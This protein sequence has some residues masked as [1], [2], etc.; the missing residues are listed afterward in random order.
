MDYSIDLNKFIDQLS[1]KSN[2]L[3][4]LKDER[5]ASAIIGDREEYEE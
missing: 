5:F 2:R 4:F 1:C 3:F